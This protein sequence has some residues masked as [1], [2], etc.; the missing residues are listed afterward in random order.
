MESSEE[1]Q[2]VFFVD[3]QQD[4]CFVESPKIFEKLKNAV[5]EKKNKRP[6]L[7]VV[8][9]PRGTG[10]SQT[11]LEFCYRNK[12]Y[13]Q[14]IFWMEA[15]TETILQNG[16]KAAAEELDLPARNNKNPEN[17][18]RVMVQWFQ[19]KSGWLLIFDNANDYSL[20][21]PSQPFQLPKKYF[22]NSGQGVILITTRLKYE[23]GRDISVVDLD[24][25]HIDDDTIQK[26]LPRECTKISGND[27]IAPAIVQE[28][29]HLPLTLDIASAHMEMKKYAPTE[30]HQNAREHL[31]SDEYITMDSPNWVQSALDQKLIDFFDLKDFDEN[32]QFLAEGGHGAIQLATAKIR[33]K[34]YVLK[35]L[36]RMPISVNSDPA[37]YQ[38]FVQ[39]VFDFWI[40]NYIFCLLL[41]FFH[42]RRARSG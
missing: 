10:K 26:A 36:F 40:A 23:L 28:P 2:G 29:K 38:A 6:K 41:C 15:S 33:K 35:R 17:V 34:Q 32:L 39:E 30:C 3:H 37:G 7:V 8:T 14:Y 18:V 11:A 22:P 16:F 27:Q 20:G 13:Y 31:N 24:E 42:H 19:Q 4:P 1:A 12:D 25:T 21:N 9:G 5:D